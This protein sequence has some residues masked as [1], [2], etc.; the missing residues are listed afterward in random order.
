MDYVFPHLVVRLSSPLD[1]TP[2]PVP[3]GGGEESPA[4]SSSA[5]EPMEYTTVQ[6]GRTL[7]G[8]GGVGAGAGSE[9]AQQLLRMN[10]TTSH[11]SAKLHEVPVYPC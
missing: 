9:I 4:A 8:G 2:F 1:L 3:L 11:G 6:A 5:L 7:G 10:E